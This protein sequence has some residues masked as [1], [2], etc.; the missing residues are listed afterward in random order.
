MKNV[1]SVVLAM[2]LALAA[3]GAFAQDNNGMAKDSMSQD[4]MSQNGNAHD[5]M[6]KNAMGHDMMKKDAMS[7]DSMDKG[8]MAKDASSH[9]MKDVRTRTA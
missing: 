8:A 5:D 2:C 9:A 3:G 6:K 7:K 1:N 4:Q